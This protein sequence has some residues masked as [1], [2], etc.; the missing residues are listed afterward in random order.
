MAAN[1]ARLV[2][3]VLRVSGKGSYWH[4]LTT[5]LSNRRRTLTGTLYDGDVLAIPW[6][7]DTLS[8]D[9]M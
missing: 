6:L 8:G 5:M 2:L 4:S 1:F 7:L 9:K 3:P